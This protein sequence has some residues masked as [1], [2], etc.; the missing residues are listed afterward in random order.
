MDNAVRF[1][2]SFPR[3][4]DESVLSLVTPLE[5]ETQP[6]RPKTYNERRR[7]HHESANAERALTLGESHVKRA[8]E[9]RDAHHEKE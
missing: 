7:P 9:Q 5:P 8:G 3:C 2:A 6:K 4:S 1:S